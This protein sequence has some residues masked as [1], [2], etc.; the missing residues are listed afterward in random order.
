MTN[1]V[2]LI[3]GSIKSFVFV[4][5]EVIDVVLVHARDQFALIVF[6][7]CQ[8]HELTLSQQSQDVQEI[9]LVVDSTVGLV[10]RLQLLLLLF[11][12]VSISLAAAEIPDK[13]CNE[14]VEVSHGDFRPSLQRLKE[15]FITTI[16]MAFFVKLGHMIR[17][18]V[19]S[20]G[21]RLF[22]SELLVAANYKLD[23]HIEHGIETS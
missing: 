10:M 2:C 16:T 9:Y 7:S 1:Q 12:P 6:Q 15:V 14:R 4:V 21:D 23:E 22:E 20:L 19:E 5:C 17:G 13:L 3:V 11:E 18:S 8:A